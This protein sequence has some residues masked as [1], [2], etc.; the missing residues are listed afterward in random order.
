MSIAR[1]GPP[2]TL[3]SSVG[4]KAMSR[5][6]FFDQ[7]RWGLNERE[8]DLLGLLLSPPRALAQ[9]LE[10]PRLTSRVELTAREREVL[11][12]VA[13]GA[14]NREVAGQLWISPHTVRTH[15]QHIFEKLDV[16][17]RTEAAALLRHTGSPRAEPSTDA[18][19]DRAH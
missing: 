12:A 4:A 15:L 10:R 6:F 14:T 13:D 18:Q 3:V 7:E 19:F 11:Q 2:I 8:R 5:F 9:P 1:S 16:R 17:T